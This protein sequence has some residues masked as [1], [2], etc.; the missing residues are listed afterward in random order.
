[1]SSIIPDEILEILV[2]KFTQIDNPEELIEQ[3]IE[4]ILNLVTFSY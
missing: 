3:D 2:E 4:T 1:M